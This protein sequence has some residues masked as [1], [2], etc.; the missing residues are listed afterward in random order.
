MYY[1]LYTVIKLNIEISGAGF[2]ASQYRFVHNENLDEDSGTPAREAD[3]VKSWHLNEE[4]AY[5]EGQQDG[6][7]GPIISYWGR[8]HC[9]NKF[10]PGN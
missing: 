7:V 9:L 3:W 5:I 8:I 2:R 4:D 10:F 6:F 1:F